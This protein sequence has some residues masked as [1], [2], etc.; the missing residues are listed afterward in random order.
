MHS[1]EHRHIEF[2]RLPMQE[3]FTCS[4]YHSIPD[5]P[6]SLQK[7]FFM[8][9]VYMREVILLNSLLVLHWKPLILLGNHLSKFKSMAPLIF[10]FLWRISKRIRER[11]ND[12]EFIVLFLQGRQGKAYWMSI[13]PRWYVHFVTIALPQAAINFQVY[14]FIQYC[15]NLLYQQ[16][17]I[18]VPYIFVLQVY[19]YP[20][21]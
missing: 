18:S 10:K 7:Q 4:S 20:T 17:Y 12:F 11:D 1:T 3:C 19:Q 13:R 6:P 9:R 16:D 5:D 2:K 14:L 8:A 15:V 21:L